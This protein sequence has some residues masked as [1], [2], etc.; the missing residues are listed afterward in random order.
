[1]TVLA[2]SSVR[3]RIAERGLDVALGPLGWPVRRWAA[4]DIDWSRAETRTP[5]QVG[6]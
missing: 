1:M 5:A 4:A 3:V 2:C 6:R